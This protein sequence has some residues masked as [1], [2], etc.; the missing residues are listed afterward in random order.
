[1]VSLGWL[2]I[3][4]L[5]QG[6]TDHNHL[7]PNVQD[8]FFSDLEYLG[9]K[10][11]AIDLV[12]FT[13]D[14][15]QSGSVA[16]FTQLAHTL[17]KLCAH[18]AKLQPGA[19][20]PLLLIV[21]GN[22]DLVRPRFDTPPERTA[23]VMLSSWE[24][25]RETADLFFSDPAMPHRQLVE[26]A[27]ANYRRFWSTLPRPAEFQE[28]ILPGDFS[29]VVTK[30]GARLGIV[31]LNSAFLQLG[32][33]DY[34]EKLALHV[35]QLS[36]VCLPTSPEWA[37][38]CDTSLLLT[39][40][41]PDWLSPQ[42]REEHLTEI[43]PPG[44]FAAHLFGHMHE[45]ATV[46]TRHN[47]SQ[48]VRLVQASA[49]FGRESYDNGKGVSVTRR[50]GYSI[51]RIQFELERGE[52]DLRIWPRQ[53]QRGTLGDWELIPDP[54]FRGLS[55]DDQGTDPDRIGLTRRHLGP[56]PVDATSATPNSG[57]PRLAKPPQPAGAPY[58]RSWYVNRTV[59]EALARKHLSQPGIPVVLT[60]PPFYGKTTLLKYLLETA[61][62]EDKPR[63][64]ESWVVNISF[65]TFPQATL[66]NL[67]TLLQ[68]L[69]ARLAGSSP[70]SASLYSG[71]ETI[72]RRPLSAVGKLDCFMHDY[73]LKSPRKPDL[74]LLALDKVE[75]ILDRSYQEDFFALLRS[76]TQHT[77]DKQW[78]SLRMI[79]AM[80]TSPMLI[81]QQIYQSPFANTAHELRI[82]DF[83][84][85][86]VTRLVRVTY[87]TPW[88][89]AEIEQLGKWVGGHPYLLRI[90][91]FHVLDRKLHTFAEAR[92]DKEIDA[93]L[94]RF[95]TGRFRNLQPNLRKALYDLQNE[96]P[97]SLSLDE[98]ERLSTGALITIE[99]GNPD[100]YKLRYG[101]Y[102]DFFGRDQVR[103]AR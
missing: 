102:H 91:L 64:H 15:T 28:G 77:G 44:R 16:E 38:G 23:R 53:A 94:H 40:H 4:D 11:G 74:L 71:M 41:P 58:N 66:D 65:E 52:A 76:W 51:G 7:W 72:W 39:H 60:G 13:G 34:K 42:S 35:R 88:S 46:G 101:I 84:T 26:A 81:G 99:P 79:L 61:L 54:Q 14:L 100:R 32:A 19:P 87:E 85:E 36:A 86:Q 25:N 92:A 22:H 98:V 1:M 50:H 63:G 49:L 97:V 95:L 27:F 93:Q 2:H 67:D 18:L 73:I 62:Q 29:C 70:D 37:K 9:R 43:A 30:G 12:L 48:S 69:A 103:R 83:T 68:E 20:P 17:D 47:N 55:K 75:R 31:G 10:L 82:G 59:E 5:H 80:S 89:D 45:Q 21:P 6:L 96:L 90:I 33:G 8:A 78:A 3:S 56:A 57:S 24:Q